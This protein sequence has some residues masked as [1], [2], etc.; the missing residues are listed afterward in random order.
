MANI[1]ALIGDENGE[2]E[3]RTAKPGKASSF[4]VG[5]NRSYTPKAKT[6][7]QTIRIKTTFGYK[8]YPFF[9]A[10]S[11][12]PVP[13]NIGERREIKPEETSLAVNHFLRANIVEALSR[14]SRQLP[15]TAQMDKAKMLLI[16]GAIILAVVL[17]YT[18]ALEQLIAWFT[19]SG[20]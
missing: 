16:G 4:Q 17:Y 12:N 6:H 11:E 13:I 3:L 19:G 15:G 18:G 14:A 1:K 5:D 20:E 10:H 9:M 7:I 2:W 8:R